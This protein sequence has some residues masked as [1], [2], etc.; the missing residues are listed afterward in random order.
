MRWSL[1]CINIYTLERV[2]SPSPHPKDKDKDKKAKEE[3]EDKTYITGEISVRV[4]NS[5]YFF[6][7]TILLICSWISPIAFWWRENRRLT[8]QA[9]WNWSL[10]LYPPPLGGLTPPLILLRQWK[11]LETLI[12]LTLVVHQKVQSM[13]PTITQKTEHKELTNIH[14]AGLSL[15][16]S[17]NSRQGVQVNPQLLQHLLTSRARSLRGKS[18]SL[19]LPPVLQEAL[20]SCLPLLPPPLLFFFCLFDHSLHLDEA[21]AIETAFREKLQLVIPPII[22][23]TS[24]F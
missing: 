12:F 11:A 14:F 4:C 6:S 8:W 21:Q 22:L 15:F 13:L 3:K 20:I 5:H 2:K 19:L 1:S 9:P 7:S 17:C 16:R 18:A 23:C 24:L 10:L